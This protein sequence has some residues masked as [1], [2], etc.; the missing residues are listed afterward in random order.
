MKNR[1]V[2]QER[3]R[4]S[5]VAIVIPT[6]NRS[7]IV[8]RAIDS[9]LAQT[10]PCEIIVCDHGSKDDT[11]QMMK[12]YKNKVK[13]IRKEEDFGPH[14][15]WLDGILHA[16]A[17][18]VHLQFDDDWIDKDYIKKCMSLMKEDVGVVIAGTIAK[19]EH[20]DKGTEIFNFKKIFKKS[21]IF[22]KRILER[23]LL[24]GKMYSPG[25]SL[26]RKKDLIDAL[27]QG[28]LPVSNYKD[29]HG[30]GPDSF[31]TLLA[32]LRYKK[33]GIIIENLVFFTGHE[34]SI[35]ADAGNTPQ[36][37]MQLKNAYKNVLDYYRFLKWFRFFDKFKYFS[38]YF[39]IEKFVSLSKRILR[40]TGLFKF[41][42]K[43]YYKRNT[44]PVD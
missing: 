34:G 4:K 27:Y 43:I 3:D 29:Y 5:K 15:C 14:F 44:P 32:V 1:T 19:G 39:W 9:S 26:F 21:G 22:K 12:K 33:V 2:K 37:Y 8:Q 36:K 25:A 28:S 7:K 17:E 10:Y 20:Q 18:F 42:Q 38:P 13:Y 6:F 35:T 30:V 11:P 16:E 24:K 23:E 41:A 40:A 31:F